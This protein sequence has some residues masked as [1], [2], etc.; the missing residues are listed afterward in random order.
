MSMEAA[1]V[2]ACIEA[3]LPGAAVDVEGADCNFTVTVI[4]D[5]FDGLLPVKRQQRVLEVFSDVLA[6]GELHALTVKTFTTREWEA[7]NTGGL[8][9]ISL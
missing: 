4:Y 9:Q 7:K 6:S 3:A 5:A 1:A 8:I 2:A